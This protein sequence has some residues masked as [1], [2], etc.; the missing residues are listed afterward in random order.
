MA[1]MIRR[2]SCHTTGA[3]SLRPMGPLA[4]RIRRWGWPVPPTPFRIRRGV[5]AIPFFP[6]SSNPPPTIRRPLPGPATVPVCPC[7]PAPCTAPVTA[8]TIYYP[9]GY[10]AA[11][12]PDPL[13]PL[14]QNGLRPQRRPY[15]AQGSGRQL[16]CGEYERHFILFR[17]YPGRQESPHCGHHRRDEQH[18]L[19]RN[20]IHEPCQLPRRHVFLRRADLHRRQGGNLSLQHPGGLRSKRPPGHQCC[21]SA[22]WGSAFSGGSLFSM[23][24]GSV[25]YIPFGYT[26]LAPLLTP[27]GGEI[28]PSD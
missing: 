22:Q 28:P 24:D 23:C 10:A 2:A 25:R 27:S 14:E 21:R 1:S 5:G 7:S 15:S 20:Q 4:R 12:Y 8:Q 26:N 18:H 17:A 16:E 6:T 3:T 9:A 13:L 11:Q 19:A